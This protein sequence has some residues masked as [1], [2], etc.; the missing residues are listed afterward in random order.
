M[1]HKIASIRAFIGARNFDRSRQFYAD[2]GFLENQV[3]ANMSYFS[4]GAFGFYLQDAYVKEWI[5]NTMIFLEVADLEDRLDKWQ[6]LDLPATY[7]GVKLSGIVNND[8]GREF[9]LHDPAGVLWHVGE[10]N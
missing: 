1:D 8:W 2:L 6:Q 10:F 9:F 7:T 3:S 4:S 5:E